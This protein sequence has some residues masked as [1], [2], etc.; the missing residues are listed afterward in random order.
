M[1]PPDG[2]EFDG[3]AEC[4]R[5]AHC[6]WRTRRHGGHPTGG[7][8]EH[9][10]SH[11]V[12]VEPIACGLNDLQPVEH[13]GGRQ[14]ARRAATPVGHQRDDPAAIWSIGS[15]VGSRALRLFNLH[16]VEQESSQSA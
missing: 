5:V 6:V 3:L 10:P 15:R 13:R 1:A 8:T 16:E 2:E 11:L 12:L 4:V 7:S 14:P 9:T